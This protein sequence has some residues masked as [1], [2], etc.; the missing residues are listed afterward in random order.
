MAEP[1]RDDRGVDA[2][3]QQAHRGG[4]TVTWNATYG[5]VVQCVGKARDWVKR[6]VRGAVAQRRAEPN[7][8]EKADTPLRQRVNDRAKSRL[9]LA[10]RCE[11]VVDE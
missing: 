3:V 9:L 5:V 11:R 1:Q 6:K 8:V 4:V 7:G 2:G 10:P